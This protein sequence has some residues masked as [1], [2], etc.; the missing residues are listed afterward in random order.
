[1]LKAS[2]GGNGRGMRPIFG[3]D[4]LEQKV[5]E[6]RRKAEAAFG[7]GEG[8]LEKMIT[9]ARHVEVQVLGDQNGAL[10]HLYE[11]DGSVQRRNQ[12]VV[13]RAPAPY[14]SEKQ[15]ERICQLGYQIC[16][17]VNYVGMGKQLRDAGAHILGV[18]DMA[19][20]S[21]PASATVLIKALKEDVG[22]PIH[23]HTHDT[24]GIAGATILAAAEAGADCV[25]VA[26]DALSGNTSQ[27]TMRS[28]VEALNNT[29]RETGL[30]ISAIRD[31][32][33]TGRVSVRITVLLNQ[34]CRHLRQRFISMRCPAGN[35]P[36][37]KPRPVPL[38]WKNAGM[39]LTFPP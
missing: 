7:N 35:L 18:K 14:L 15:R 13:E 29:E 20:L 8:Y 38:A 34:A 19:G 22:V 1:M 39:R 4:E 31:I 28:I 30:D 21:K 5:L 32:S 9:R 3:P 16:K 17:H 27:P 11:R 24:S 37:R 10:Y 2:W 23:F 12:K 6:G 36:T 33:N 26:M 25:Y